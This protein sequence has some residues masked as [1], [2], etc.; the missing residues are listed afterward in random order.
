MAAKSVPYAKSRA[1]TLLE[2]ALFLLIITLLV[3]TV[4]PAYFSILNEARSEESK[5]NIEDISLE[6][7]EFFKANGRYPESL[8]EI[9]TPVPLDPWG[10]PYQYTRIDGGGIHGKGKQRKDKNLVPINSDYDL[11]SMG[12]DG[13]SVPPL[14]ANASRDDIVRGRNGAFFGL[15]SEY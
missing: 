2:F 5:V 8:S 12:P 3:S 15:A 13:Q 1:F 11:Y 10:N 4:R 9:M 7:D 6:I 14:T